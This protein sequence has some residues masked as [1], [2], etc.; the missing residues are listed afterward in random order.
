MSTTIKNKFEFEGKWYQ[1]EPPNKHARL[2]NGTLLK[3]VTTDGDGNA[4]VALSTKK[5]VPDSEISLA[6]EIAAMPDSPSGTSEKAD[7]DAKIAKLKE[8]WVAYAAQLSDIREQQKIVEADMAA[9]LLAEK[10]E[11]GGTVPSVVLGGVRFRGQ[12]A[13]K[14]DTA[15]K[16][17]PATVV[18]YRDT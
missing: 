5:S 6:V 14:G 15:P 10:T 4:T 9:A 7:S 3:I 11:R 13:R 18:V 17:V 1:Q 2:E 12:R 16:L 8:L